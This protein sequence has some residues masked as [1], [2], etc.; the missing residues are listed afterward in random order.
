MIERL[1]ADG[2]LATID[3]LGEDTTDRQQATAVT[4]E[5]IAA[6]GAGWARPSWP[7]AA[8]PRCR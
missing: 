2:L 1:L 8:G 7:R 4:D 6:A 3:Y 5:Y